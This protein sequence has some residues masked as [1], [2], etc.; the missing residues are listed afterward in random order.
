MSVRW[1]KASRAVRHAGLVSISGGEV[2][3]ARPDV[4]GSYIGS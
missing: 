1:R 2:G 3:V 4:E